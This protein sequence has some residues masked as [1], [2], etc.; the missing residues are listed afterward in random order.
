MEMGEPRVVV[1]DEA[2]PVQQ[3]QQDPLLG[4]L[5]VNALARALG[6]QE[7]EEKQPGSQQQTRRNSIASQFSNLPPLKQ[8]SDSI[9]GTTE[10]LDILSAHGQE[11]VN[12]ISG[13][14]REPLF[15]GST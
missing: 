8:G 1:V 7:E 6:M 3:M 5:D 14:S 9:L 10:H 15:G 13:D 11:H 12:S 2:G 4:N